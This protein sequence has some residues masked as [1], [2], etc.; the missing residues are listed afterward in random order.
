[1]ATIFKPDFEYFGFHV[2][3]AVHTVMEKKSDLSHIWSKDQIWATCIGWKCRAAVTNIFFFFFFTTSDITETE[4][5]KPKVRIFLLPFIWELLQGCKKKF[6]QDEPRHTN[7][8]QLR[9]I[10]ILAELLRCAYHLSYSLTVSQRYVRLVPY[11]GDRE[12]IHCCSWWRAAKQMLDWRQI[13]SAE[14]I[15]G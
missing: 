15:W 12:I 14:W 13:R 9:L 4:Q 5:L 6:R 7:M 8:N 1:M 3:S 11:W 2:H 10:Y